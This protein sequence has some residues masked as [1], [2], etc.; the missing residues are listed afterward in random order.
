MINSPGR[1]RRRAATVLLV[2]AVVVALNVAAHLAL[3]ALDLSRPD[4]LTRP[5]RPDWLALPG[6]LGWLKPT[7]KVVR[8]VVIGALIVVTLI[9]VW[10]QHRRD[11]G[12]AD[13]PREH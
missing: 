11:A 13:Q 9:G 1:G 5:D 8:V 10:E 4:W 3:P 12:G 6:W 2:L 7:A